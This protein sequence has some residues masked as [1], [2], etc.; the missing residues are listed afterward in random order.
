MASGTVLGE[1]P[2]LTRE[3]TRLA[4]DIRAAQTAEQLDAC[5]AGSRNSATGCRFVAEDQVELRGALV[6]L[7]QLI[8]EN[9]S[10][11]G[12]GRP[13][14]ARPGVAGARPARPAARPPPARR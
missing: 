5:P 11:L 6:H 12:G 3:A 14:A 4:A 9:I 13:V 8:V 2:D 1:A 7:L 10:E